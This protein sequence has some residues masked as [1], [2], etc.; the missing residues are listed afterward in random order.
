MPPARRDAAMSQNP[1]IQH[2]EEPL[3]HQIRAV[4]EGRGNAGEVLL[5]QA[6]WH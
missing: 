6:A 2:L 5:V 4:P 3:F 1:P